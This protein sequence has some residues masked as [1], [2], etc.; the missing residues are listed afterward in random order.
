MRESPS[1]ELIKLLEEKGASVDYHDPFVPTIGMSREYA[2]L[3]GRS[4]QEL[5]SNYDCF[6]LATK[7]STFSKE[8]I[9]SFG[10]PIV[11]T[12]NFLPKHKQVFQA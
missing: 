8:E 12:R 4:S 7:H 5:S 3:A 2:Q 10:I 9:L 1:L 6:L 11:D